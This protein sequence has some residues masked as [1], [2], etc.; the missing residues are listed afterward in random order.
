MPEYESKYESRFAYI[1]DDNL[2]KHM[3]DA[4]EFIA[5]LLTVSDRFPN[6]KKNY[7]YKTCIL[8]SASLIESN[9]HFCILKL[10]FTEYKSSNWS[11]KL[12]KELHVCDDWIK[13][14]SW[15]REKEMISIN[16]TID[17]NVLNSFAY[18]TAWIYN[19]NM[20]NK[21]DKIRKLRNQIHL[22][23]LEDIDRTFSQNQ[24]NEV[25]DTSRELF[26]LIEKKLN[27]I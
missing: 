6:D 5:D 11:Y 13:I 8:Y 24:L 25:F 16:W 2:R 14:M 21:I 12:I 22:M 3:W 23:K 4:M 10:W 17:F 15:K 7:F 1:D 26:K 19:E 27:Q 18:K 20:F 9:I